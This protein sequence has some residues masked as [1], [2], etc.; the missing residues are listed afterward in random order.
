MALVG[1]V[2]DNGWARAIV[3]LLVAVLLP[4]FIA[5]RLLPD[6]GEARPKGLVSDVLATTWMTVPVVMAIAL[7]AFTQP[8][9][10]AEGD[11]LRQSRLNSLAAVV[12]KMAAVDPDEAAPSPTVPSTPSASASP[13]SSAPP[14]P[15]AKATAS[16]SGAAPVPVPDPPKPDD[17]LSPADLFR[18]WAPAVV[19]VGV[20][21]PRGTGGGTGFLID[22]EGTIAT[23]YHV[24]DHAEEGTIKFKNGAIYDDIM[25]L[26]ADPDADLA[27][28]YVE[29]DKPKEG[30]APDDVS[31][32]NL[33]DS[34]TIEVGERTISIGNPL[35]LEHTLT[36][37]VVSARR[38]WRDKNWIQMST[39]VSPG[40]SG[41]PVFKGRGEVI[42]VTTAIVGPGYAQ[43]LN[44][45]VPINVLKSKIE[46]DY[47][48]QRK[49]G[50]S[51][52]ASSW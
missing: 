31:S 5:D 6:D 1:L 27:L 47:P 30:E 32:A 8:V 44:L 33:G 18:A 38:V 14:P 45:A 17:E 43:N 11:R 10:A 12:Y 37:G 2:T 39:P 25:V 3:A 28:L 15:Q 21:G 48:A 49:L 4:A 24:I 40:N 46:K 35:G 29:L 13:S 50:Q 52:G 7:N 26:V 41:G 36:T 19:S 34:E 51:G 23:N 20:K 22:E 9:L 42:G 16:V